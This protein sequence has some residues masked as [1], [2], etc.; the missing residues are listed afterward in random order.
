MSVFSKSKDFVN[1]RATARLFSNCVN[2]KISE[3]SERIFKIK[4]FCK[5]PS[6]S[7]IIFKFA[8]NFKR[9][10]QSERIFVVKYN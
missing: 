8:E 3:Q 4:R 1:L 5:S 10:E 2:F 9:H 6:N 7:E